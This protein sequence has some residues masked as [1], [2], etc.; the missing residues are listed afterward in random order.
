MN[1][2]ITFILLVCL[3]QV[4]TQQVQCTLSYHRMH[5]IDY[6]E[7]SQQYLFRG[8]FPFD[9]KSKEFDY[10]TLVDFLKKKAIEER[11]VTL[12]SQFRI[13]DIT[14][15]QDLIN[16][17]E[18]K[19]ER[20]FFQKNPTL[21]HVKHWTIIGHPLNASSLSS[22][23]RKKMALF[24]PDWDIEDDLI[25]RVEQLYQWIHN[26]TTSEPTV[27]YIHCS[28]GVD[29]TGELSGAYYMKY[30]NWSFNQAVQFDYQVE[31]RP[32]NSWNQNAMNWYC[33]WMYY[34]IGRPSDC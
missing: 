19:V 28:A 1:T 34:T 4:L 18:L 5:V 26:S 32:I 31:P 12:P 29:R 11:N 21:G 8:N 22:S 25:N 3:L 14:L 33:W 23:T 6:N 20:E 13:V 15:L 2:T 9:S 7:K 24:T 30:L 27:Y 16:R 17:S 10:N